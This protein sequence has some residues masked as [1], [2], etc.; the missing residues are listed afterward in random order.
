VALYCRWN[1]IPCIPFYLIGGLKPGRKALW[2]RKFPGLKQ[3]EGFLRGWSFQISPALAFLNHIEYFRMYD[4][5]HPEYYGIDFS[6]VPAKLQFNTYNPAL[7]YPLPKSEAKKEMKLDPAKK[8]LI[9]VSRLFKEKGLHYV[10][11]I[12]PRL[13]EKHPD[14][15]LLVIGAFIEEAKE[16]EE[17]IKQ[18]IKDKN[19][20]SRVTFLGR[21]EHHEGLVQYI[22]SAEAFVLPTYMD[23]FAAVNIE[24]LA[25]EVPV[26]STDRDE[27]P[28]YLLPE[29]GFCVPQHD[30]EALY[31][32]CDEILS[33][34]F[35]F[36]KKKN[37]EILA[38]YNY[39]TAA[40]DMISWLR[41]K[42]IVKA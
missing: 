40:A 30:N 41:E 24:A 16:Y 25:C 38:K 2:M 8:Y 4:P 34:R 28:Y 29:V 32:A 12:L 36:D 21:V 10:L 22:N 27:I 39:K 9:L 7:F 11:E 15:H 35:V 33:G 17:E 1:K 37:Q 20:G 3:L 31:K 18:F 42:K 23:T 6:S 26:I 13:A 19:L 5:K 14:V